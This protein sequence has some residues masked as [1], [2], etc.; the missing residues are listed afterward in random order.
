MNK[1]FVCLDYLRIV[2]AFA[3]VVLH[4][5]SASLTYATGATK[6]AVIAMHFSTILTSWAVPVFFIITGFLWL[7]DDKACSFKT[8]GKHI[9]KFIVTLF[10]VG[11][12]YGFLEIVFNTH[13]FNINST[14]ES[15]KNVLTGNL[16][17]HMWYV[18]AVIGIYMI[19]PLIKPF[20]IK[21]NIKDDMILLS[22]S[23]F[24]TVILPYVEKM[25][26]ISMPVKFA[27]TSWIFYVM[28]GGI[29]SKHK[30]KLANLKIRIISVILIILSVIAIVIKYVNNPGFHVVGYKS[31]SVCIMAAAITVLIIS[32]ENKFPVKKLIT[33][34]SVCCWGI[35]LIHPFVI[36]LIIKFIK[37]NPL[38]YLWII[39][40]P[41]T[42][43][44][45]FALCAISIWILRKIPLIK[46]YIF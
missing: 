16:W 24:W 5:T 2:C 36:N 28:L 11:W 21:S 41:L 44:L 42:C 22:L 10:T 19:L 15:L 8:V 45:I 3:I 9:L 13:S 18:Y 1:R 35:Y 38:D 14:L 29:I 4:V 37:F 33:E 40:I 46:K 17:D 23:F 27:A 12:L 39:T 7:G 30:E 20:F 31:L 34:I 25:F 26:S 6:S 43:I 32:Y